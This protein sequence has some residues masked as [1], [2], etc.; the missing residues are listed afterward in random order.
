MAALTSNRL[1]RACAHSSPLARND[2]RRETSL[3]SIKGKAIA[4][5]CCSNLSAMK[6]NRTLF[7]NTGH[8]LKRIAT[9]QRT[10]Q[11]TGSQ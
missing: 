5:E 7:A 11:P 9:R 3:R 1:R 10:I 6:H 4:Q 2:D 8:N